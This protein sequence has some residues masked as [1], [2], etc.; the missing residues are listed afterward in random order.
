[1]A[2]QDRLAVDRSV[3]Q[4]LGV[5]NAE[6]PA[7]S[8]AACSDTNEFVGLL[9]QDHGLDLLE[10][11]VGLLDEQAE[12]GSGVDSRLALDFADVDYLRRRRAVRILDGGLDRNAHGSLPNLEAAHRLTSARHCAPFLA[13]LTG[14]WTAS[15]E[16]SGASTFVHDMD[17]GVV[18]IGFS[19][20]A[21]VTPCEKL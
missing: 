19:G 7:A 11:G 17:L 18:L 5:L 15:C 3:P 1:M 21:F 9:V 10:Q 2:A 6:A 8:D 13:A 20:T 14:G 12:S 16:A 4:R